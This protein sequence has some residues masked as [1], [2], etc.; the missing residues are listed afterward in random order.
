VLAAR[1]LATRE[2]LMPLVFVHGVNTRRGTAS[3]EQKV[4]DDRVDLLKEQFRVAFADRVAATDGLRV[5]APYWGDL[6]VT[7]SRNLAC[8]PQSGVQ[9]LATTNPS[10][11]ALASSVAG[12]L[13]AEIVQDPELRTNPLLT[14]A[15]SRSLSTAV[16]LLFAASSNSSPPDAFAA[17]MKAAFP[18]AA[19]FAAAAEQ[20]AA[21]N[22]HPSWLDQP[23]DDQGF[24]SSLFAAI[25]AQSASVPAVDTDKAPKIQSLGIG[26]DV[27]TWLKFGATAARD[28]ANTVTDSIT[29][30]I[31]S[32]GRG[33][34]MAAFIELSG[35]VRPAASSFIGRFFGD[36]FKYLE[37]RQAIQDRVVTDVQSAL[38]ARRDGD[39]ELYLIGHSFG[40]IILYDILTTCKT[41]P[42]LKSDLYVTVGSQVALFAEIDRLADHA[43]IA[44]AF[45]KGTQS[46][47]P[48]PT[49]AERWINIFDLTDLVGFGTRGV[50]KGVWDYRFNTDAL[51]LIS[52]SAYFDTPR[53]FARLRERVNEA[54]AKG[55]DMTL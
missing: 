22:P 13:D 42:V 52:H 34:T 4:F 28:A 26:N 45:T 40:G 38:A 12:K 6:G 37:N 14:I 8:L 51:P 27:L 32:A 46:V 17:A 2:N 55:T 9:A 11:A 36:V 35:Y 29:S 25:Q 43:G 30:A 7:F 16:D 19:R 50:F 33:A 53:F 39:K 44:N 49:N 47:V 54:F 1:E 5:F 15:R 3:G 31:G 20:Y 21:A 41:D 48:R 23:T 18:E 10:R 24:T